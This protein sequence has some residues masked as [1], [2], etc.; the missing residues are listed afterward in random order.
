[1]AETLTFRPGP[2]KFDSLIKF[3]DSL[4]DGTADILSSA[5]EVDARPMDEL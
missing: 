1:M 4:L 3:F 5:P 2:T